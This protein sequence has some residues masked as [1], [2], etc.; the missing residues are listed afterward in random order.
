MSSRRVEREKG[1]DPNRKRAHSLGD[2]AKA[3]QRAERRRN[4]GSVEAADW[5]SADAALIHRLI[6][7]AS[8]SGAAVQFGLTRD[9]GAFRI[10]IL[11]GGDAD[12][13]YV[14]PSEDLGYALEAL[15]LDFEDS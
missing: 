13:V 5:S 14:R 8:R 7:S 3:K 2:D 9:G 1:T 4:R 10:R 12:D 15:A 11:D 6:V